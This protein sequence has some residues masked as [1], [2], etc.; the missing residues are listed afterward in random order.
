MAGS[1][2]PDGLQSFAAMAIFVLI[3]AVPLYHIIM[4][5]RVPSFFH[6]RPWRVTLALAA[7]S[8]VAPAAGFALYWWWC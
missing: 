6:R 8:L 4:W 1:Y 5:S 2:V 3:C 7:L